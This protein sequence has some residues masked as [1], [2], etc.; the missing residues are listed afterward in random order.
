MIRHPEAE[1]VVRRLTEAGYSGW[2]VLEWE[3]CIKDGEQGA[4]EGAEAIKRFMI[5]TPKKAFDDFAG[6]GTDKARNRKIL[7]LE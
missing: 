3:C 6:S 4:A 1:I 7:G 2:A 5:E